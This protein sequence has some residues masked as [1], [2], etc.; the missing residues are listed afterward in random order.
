MPLT[1]ENLLVEKPHFIPT[2]P[3]TKLMGFSENRDGSVQRIYRFANGHGLSVVN[4]PVLHSYPFAWEAA[5][6]GDVDDEGGF[7]GLRY[8]T[9]LTE[10]VEVFYTDEEANDFIDRAARWGNDESA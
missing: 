3:F 4:N 9:P 5:V 7:S 1:D 10:D 2:D 6:I 8:D